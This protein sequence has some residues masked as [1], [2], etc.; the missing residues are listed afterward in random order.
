MRTI[1]PLLYLLL[2]MPTALLATVRDWPGAAPCN[3]SFMECLNAAQAGD[4]I[5]LYTNGPISDRI[6]IERPVSLVA[7]PGYQPVFNATENHAFS[8][9]SAAPFSLTLSGLRFVGSSVY[10]GFY[11]TGAGDVVLEG[12]SFTGN[13]STVQTQIGVQMQQTGAQ[14]SRLR[15]LRSR[16]QI[17]SDA[18]APYSIALFGSSN[19]GLDVQIED[20]R[21]A[22]EPQA[23]GANAHLAVFAL[24]SGNSR[25]DLAF[26]RNQILPAAALPARRYA[27]GIEWDT[28]DASTVYMQLSDNLFVLDSIDGAGGAAISAGGTNGGSVDLRAINNTVLG[29]YNAL[30]F[31][32]NVSG[33]VDNS[34][35][36]GV[37]R[38]HEGQAAI[39]AFQFRNN[40][41]VDIAQSSSWSIPL[42]TLTLPAQVSPLGVPLPGSPLIDGGS[43][44]ARAEAGPGNYTAP[45]P[46]DGWGLPRVEG[47]HIDIGAFEGERIYYD[48]AE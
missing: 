19:A 46:R 4:T 21:F 6:V 26:R 42:G 16:F 13:A 47:A 33:R 2:W 43:D 38:L 10:V 28:I 37:V 31:R 15:V 24:L 25:Y 39:S 1:L 35:I 14:R 12:L 44:S 41:M 7:A 20:N 17:G 23:M 34:L 48:G 8:I 30:A 36:S 45:V 29:A 3:L 22:P 5:R 32:A 40:L 11:G 9:S 18:G 27:N